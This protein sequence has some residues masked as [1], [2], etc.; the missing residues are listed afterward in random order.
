[1]AVRKREKLIR[2]DKANC[3]VVEKRVP[4]DTTTTT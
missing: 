3:Q 2:D 1:M 4:L